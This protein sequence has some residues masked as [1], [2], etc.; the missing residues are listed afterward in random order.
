MQIK[1]KK[2]NAKAQLPSYATKN[3]TG[4][5]LSACIDNAVCLHVGESA[6][7]PTGIA[8]QVPDGLEAQIRG[9]N[10]LAFRHAIF[11][12]HDTIDADNHD[13]IRVLLTNQSKKDFVIHPDMKVAQLVV[14]AQAVIC[15][16]EFEKTVN[17]YGGHFEND[18]EIRHA[19]L[20]NFTPEVYENH[21]KTKQEEYVQPQFRKGAPDQNEIMDNLLNAGR[22][23]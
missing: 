11:C 23:K 6:L 4:M 21:V 18:E 1:F 16:P 2:L 22:G 8:I 10:G 20:M 3:S 5:D 15:R 13:E 12:F 14:S 19:G 7:V 9:R 17:V